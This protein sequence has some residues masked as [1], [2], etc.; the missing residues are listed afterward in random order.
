MNDKDVDEDDERRLRQVQ[1][2]PEK[3]PFVVLQYE[4]Y[5]TAFFMMTEMRN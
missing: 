5:A 1:L 4:Q 3:L 2:T